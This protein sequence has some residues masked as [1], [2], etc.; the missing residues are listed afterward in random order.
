MNSNRTA[1]RTTALVCAFAAMA[2]MT[3]LTTGCAVVRGQETT[4]S[5]IDDAG[6]TTAVKAKML[7]DKTVA[8][9]SISVETLNG[10]VQLSGFAK[11]GA[12]KAQ[13]ENIA[14]GVKNVKSVRNNIVVRP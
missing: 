8:G 9:T 6:I 13:A 4:G 11:S 5:Y 1:L 2:G 12:E 7:E 14:R 3:V 10:T